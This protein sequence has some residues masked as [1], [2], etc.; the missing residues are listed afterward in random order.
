MEA[1]SLSFNE[2]NHTWDLVQLPKNKK[3]ISVK[4]VFKLK[5]DP[6]GGNGDWS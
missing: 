2:R 6:E 4:W 3:P 5:L 1:G